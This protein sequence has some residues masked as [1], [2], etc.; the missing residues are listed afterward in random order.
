MP[1]HEPQ[2][3][4]SHER[5]HAGELGAVPE[6][7]E[8]P[9]TV[10]VSGEAMYLDTAIRT[11]LVESILTRLGAAAGGSEAVL[12]GSLAESHADQYSDIDVLWDVP[13]AVFSTCIANVRGVLESIRPVESFRSDPD[14]QNSD[15]RRLFFV[16]FDRIPLFWRLDLDVY[17]HS[18]HRDSTYAA[19]NPN[20]RGDEWSQ[21]ESALANGVAA[22]KMSLRHNE[23]AAHALLKCAYHRI[24]LAMPQGDVRQ[25]AGVGG[26]P[27]WRKMARAGQP[28][29]LADPLNLG[30]GPACPH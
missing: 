15:R 3:P 30:K 20:A 18:V 6:Q 29:C 24:G 19:D 4:H 17:A 27:V 12:R 14:W 8:A 26:T 9:E 10:T 25:P 13:D 28:D 22:V 7:R 23:E 21:T 2:T 16:R 11:Q 1:E 5:R